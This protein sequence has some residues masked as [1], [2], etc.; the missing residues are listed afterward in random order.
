MNTTTLRLIRFFSRR[1]FVTVGM[2]LWFCSDF[3]FSQPNPG[4]QYLF[5][6]WR[7]T[8]S[9]AHSAQLS[10][11]PTN[12]FQPIRINVPQGVK[13]AVAQEGGYVHNEEGV[14]VFGFLTGHNYRLR[15]NNIPLYADQELY[16][17]L[18][19]VNRL[20]PPAGK[21]YEFPVVVD[22]TREDIE[23]ALKGHLV[24]R[25]IYLE[26]PEGAIPVDSTQASGKVSVDVR[27]GVDPLAVAESRGAVMAIFRIGSRLPT[28]EPN[29][30][31]PY[32]FRLPPVQRKN[33][34]QE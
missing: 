21:E 17:S 5:P 28:E 30:I 7:P 19:V 10:G 3:A 33:S 34:I 25:I 15:L 31:S 27:D 20:Y 32:F 16:P 9:V 11:V 1:V 14:A 2:I 4:G 13:V 26:N 6:A 23:L 29:L 22:V 8:G 24:T 12:Y 18:E